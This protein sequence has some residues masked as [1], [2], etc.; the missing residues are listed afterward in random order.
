MT[1]S[2][3]FCRAPLNYSITMTKHKT[4][5]NWSRDEIVGIDQH[6]LGLLSKIQFLPSR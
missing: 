6:F 3:Y 5:F 2:N 4:Y 1:E